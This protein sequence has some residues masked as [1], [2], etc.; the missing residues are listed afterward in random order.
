M[1]A[2]PRLAAAFMYMYWLTGGSCES[3]PRKFLLL[4]LL[5]I[6]GAARAHGHY[7]LTKN[8]EPTTLPSTT[9][10]RQRARVKR[11]KNVCKSKGVLRW[12]ELESTYCIMSISA[13]NTGAWAFF[14]MPF[15]TTFRWRIFLK[16]TGIN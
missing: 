4:R 8:Q 5:V 10:D 2:P 11:K 3:V 6:H 13:Q 1:E 14:R 16:P 12:R 15:S 9:S 7:S